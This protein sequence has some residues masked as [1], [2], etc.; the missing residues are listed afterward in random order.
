MSHHYIMRPYDVTIRQARQTNL[1]EWLLQNNEPLK[2]AGQWWYIEGY[3]SFR[4]QGN[5]WYRNSQGIGGNAIDFLV[6]YYGFT[7]KEAIE[8]L[9]QN[10]GCYLDRNYGVKEKN[11]KTHHE[12]FSDG[13]DFN[14]S[15]IQ[16]SDQRRT[17][18]YLIKTRGIAEDIVLAEIQNG[19]L[20][21]EADTNNSVF[22]M[23]NE[24]GDIVGAEVV[25]TLSYSS[26][27]YKGIK[28]GSASGYGYS[29]GQKQNPCYIL[30]F[31]SA[32]D[33]LSFVTIKRN[34]EKPMTACLLISMA[35]LKFDV[36][37]KSLK[38][39]GNSDAIPVLCV[40]ND[41]AGNEF[42]ARCLTQYPQTIIKQPDKRFKD[43]NDQLVKL[44]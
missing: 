29:I 27:R 21:Q 41:M 31:E 36:V 7:L 22:A 18:A 16:A 19:Q 9:T 44:S 25:G 33:L 8:M 40:D 12:M 24:V 13:F 2:Q 23:T 34:Q 5:K 6:V 26:I 32:V 1:V 4:I 28:A 37:K 43:W 15:V 11:I 3:D 42:I 10:S 20:F 35:G 17:L 39:F 14:S 38:V 30:Y